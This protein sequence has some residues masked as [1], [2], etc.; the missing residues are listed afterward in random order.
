MDKKYKHIFFDLDHTLWDFDRNATEVLHEL[1]D[2]FSFHELGFF[3]KEEFVQVFHVV[4]RDLWRMHDLGKINKNIIR[5]NRFRMIFNRLGLPDHHIP[6]DIGALY[7]ELC[8]VKCN[9]IPYAH[10]VLAFL[11]KHYTLHILTNGFEDIQHLKLKSAYL[12]Q[13]FIEIITAE[14]SGY[15]K[16][17]IEMFKFALNKAGA[18]CEECVMIG[19]NL[20]TD[21]VGARDAKIDQ[22]FYNPFQVTHNETVTHEIKCLSDLFEIF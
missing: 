10:E 17:N 12:D 14:K 8:P 9:V 4:N 7:L 19:D 16:P 18:Q 22:I 5:D 11:S 2:K 20:E 21:I 13:Y 6:L 3:K 15:K 1:Y